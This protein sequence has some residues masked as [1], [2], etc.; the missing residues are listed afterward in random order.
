M[1]LKNL[2]A[3]LST[4]AIPKYPNFCDVKHLK[5]HDTIMSIYTWDRHTMRTLMTTCKQRN[6]AMF[7]YAQRVSQ[8]SFKLS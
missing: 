6:L 1:N 8:N 7:G 5:V 2:W 4:K 3:V